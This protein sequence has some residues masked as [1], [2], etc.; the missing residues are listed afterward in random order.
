MKGQ[1]TVRLYRIFEVHIIGD[2]L[3]KTTLSVSQGD[4][5]QDLRGLAL[6]DFQNGGNGR[7]NSIVALPLRLVV[8]SY[9]A[10][11]PESRYQKISIENHKLDE[12][13]MA[14]L[15]N[16]PVPQYQRI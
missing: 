2:E 3:C 14:I 4:S 5:D 16:V 1:L 11:P 10:L 12:S 8:E 13:V 15:N 7:A 9:L 6:K